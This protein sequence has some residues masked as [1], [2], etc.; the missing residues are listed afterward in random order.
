MSAVEERPRVG[1]RPARDADSLWRRLFEALDEVNAVLAELERSIDPSSRAS[2]ARLER[3]RQ[4]IADAL[5]LA[6]TRSPNG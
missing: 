3:L 5:Y 2:F 1:Q 4:D 6:A